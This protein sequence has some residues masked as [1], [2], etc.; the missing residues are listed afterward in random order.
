MLFVV[1][2][3]LVLTSFNVDGQL[4]E[5]IEF[6]FEGHCLK[7]FYFHVLTVRSSKN[8]SVNNFISFTLNLIS[9][10]EDGY[11]LDFRN[12]SNTGS[13]NTM[14]SPMN[15]LNNSIEILG[16]TLDTQCQNMGL[17]DKTNLTTNN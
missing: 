5:R 7:R 8:F 13:F 6:R 16:Y 12:N 2:I 15:I 14:P 11:V 9:R 1:D 3:H 10:L 4:D 17:Q